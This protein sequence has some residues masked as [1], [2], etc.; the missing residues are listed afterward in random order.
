MGII[1]VKNLWYAY[2]PGKYV[3]EDITLSFDDRPTAIVGENGAGKTT[4][5]KLLKG[6]LKPVK[7]DVFIKGQ[8]TKEA[9]VAQLAKVIGL[10]FQNPSDQIFKSKVIDEVMFGPLNIF[11]DKHLSYEK[12]LK[13]LELVGLEDK[14]EIHPY[15]LTLSERKLLCLASVLA[16]EPEIV[17]LDEPTIAQDRYSISRIAEIVKNL[18]QSGKIILTITHDMDFVL[19]NFERTIVFCK[20]KVISDG[21]TKEVL[22]DES[23]II[24]AHL[25]LPTLYKLRKAIDKK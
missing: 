3:L 13:A 22:K 19:E 4:F 14:K 10:V 11:K 17:I 20:G 15:D 24:Q 21:P 2:K 5:V 9:T 12:S 7:G 18:V 16:M 8:N 25:E 1:E 23:K 6:L